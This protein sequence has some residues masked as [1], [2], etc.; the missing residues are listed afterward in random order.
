MSDT[1]L[2]TD[3]QEFLQL[4]AQLRRLHPMF[5]RFAIDAAALWS[6]DEF[7]ERLHRAD[8]RG[9]VHIGRMN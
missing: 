8:M 6:D 2:Y 5:R 1:G 7:I 3:S 9:D 4:V